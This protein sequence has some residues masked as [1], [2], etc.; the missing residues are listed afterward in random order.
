MLITFTTIVN[1][2]EKK[3]FLD[4]LS[5]YNLTL[6]S[7]EKYLYQYIG[8]NEGLSISFIANEKDVVKV[9]YTFANSDKEKY[10]DKI[11]EVTKNLMPDNYE[12]SGNLSQQLLKALDLIKEERNDEIIRVGGVRYDI[13]LL[14]GMINIQASPTKYYGKF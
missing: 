8:N 6:I 7:Q 13:I 14:N 1:S 12:R 10:S 11:A 4:K 5:D 9:I 2:A 3:F